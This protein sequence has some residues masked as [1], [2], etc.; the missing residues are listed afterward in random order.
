MKLG[1]TPD[2]MVNPPDLPE[3]TSYLWGWF[4]DLMRDLGLRDETPKARLVGMH[5]FRSTLM[6]R[7][8]VLRVV[9][10]EVI[11][12]HANKVTKLERVVDGQVEGARSD[13]VIGYQG[14]LPLDQK[15]EILERINYGSLAFHRPAA[16]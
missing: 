12:G 7:A 15:M 2:A 13:V 1:I 3:G 4:I 6:N 8:M 14:D 16:A 10:I 5:A 9:G 11:T